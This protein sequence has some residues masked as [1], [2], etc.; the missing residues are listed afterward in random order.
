MIINSTT[1]LNPNLEF[2]R[3]GEEVRGRMG[4]KLE[5]ILLFAGIFLLGGGSS[6]N[7]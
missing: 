7:L 2:E 5:R 6:F 3:L 1:Q 4:T